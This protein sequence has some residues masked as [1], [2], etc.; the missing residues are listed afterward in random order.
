MISFF[1]NKKKNNNYNKIDNLSNEYLNMYEAAI[2][3]FEN[4]YAPYSNFKVGASVLLRDGRIVT[5]CNVENASYG[6]TM[7]AERNA[8]F[9]AYALG[10]KKEDVSALLVTGVTETPISPCGA[11][12]QVITELMEKDKKVVLTNLDKKMI[13]YKVMDLLPYSFKEDDLHE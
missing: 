1:K 6:L 12:R 7:C 3:A 8:L 10:Y 4:A 5:G 13:V 11:C 9:A 2:T